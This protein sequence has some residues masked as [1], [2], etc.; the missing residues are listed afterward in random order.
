MRLVPAWIHADGAAEAAGS[1]ALLRLAG[2][3][4]AAPARACPRSA[5]GF[6]ATGRTPAARCGGPTCRAR[7][8]AGRAQR[9]CAWPRRRRRSTTAARQRNRRAPRGASWSGC[10]GCRCAAARCTRVR[11]SA[12]HA[13]GSRRRPPRRCTRPVRAGESCGTGGRAFRP[14]SWRAARHRPSV[15]YLAAGRMALV[16]LFTIVRLYWREEEPASY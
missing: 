13:G 12:R 10:R 11:S 6:Q 7:P 16:G 9:R 5:P 14:V 3:R 2:L 15:A 8:A 1:E 4:A